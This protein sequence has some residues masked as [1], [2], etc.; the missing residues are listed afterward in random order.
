[1]KGG[2]E[3][4][5]GEY[6]IGEVPQST[7]FISDGIH[8]MKHRGQCIQRVSNAYNISRKRSKE[9]EQEGGERKEKK[10]KD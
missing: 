8:E 7:Y 10:N 9:Q 6:I 4:D 5:R 3:S 1:M 2:G